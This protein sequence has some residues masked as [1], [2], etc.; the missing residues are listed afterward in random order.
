MR[1]VCFTVHAAWYLKNKKKKKKNKGETIMTT[2]VIS[3]AQVETYSQL[4]EHDWQAMLKYIVRLCDEKDFV[5][6]ADKQILCKLVTAAR[7]DITHSHSTRCIEAIFQAL[8]ARGKKAY[9]RKILRYVSAACGWYERVTFSD[10]GKGK[11][12]IEECQEPFLSVAKDR[13]GYTVHFAQRNFVHGIKSI[14]KQAWQSLEAK[15]AQLDAISCLDWTF[16]KQEDT[17][18]KLI[19]ASYKQAMSQLRYVK[20]HPEDENAIL[21]DALASNVLAILGKQMPEL[22]SENDMKVFANAANLQGGA[23]PIVL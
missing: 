9:A 6:L 11:A 15:K 3:Y 20:E 7:N 5:D 16:V 18:M 12:V 1:R 10:K 14:R 4:A 8:A 19:S 17:G 23:K 13:A 2:A 21:I 22:L